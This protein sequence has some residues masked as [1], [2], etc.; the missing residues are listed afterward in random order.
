MLFSLAIITAQANET[1]AGNNQLKITASSNTGANTTQTYDTASTKF[2]ITRLSIEA[3]R[4]LASG[5]G[6]ITY[7]NEYLQVKD[8][9]I[10]S[11]IKNPTVYSRIENKITFNFQTINDLYEFKES[12][13][14]M[15]IKFEIL[16][17]GETSIN[18]NYTEFT[19]L[20]ND[21]PVDVVADNQIVDGEQFKDNIEL[22]SR[23]V[24]FRVN[25]KTKHNGVFLSTQTQEYD[26]EYNKYITV[27]IGFNTSHPI[28]EVDGTLSYD[29]TKLK[30]ISG[31]CPFSDVYEFPT[32]YTSDF[33]INAL[34]E[35]SQNPNNIPFP[36]SNR[37]L[38]T[39]TFEL[40]QKGE[41]NLDIIYNDIFMF[42]GDD[43]SF[44]RL[45]DTNGKIED[46]E[47]TAGFSNDVTPSEERTAD[48]PTTPTDFTVP[49]QPIPSDATTIKLTAPK[50]SM[51]VGSTMTVK[52]TITNQFGSVKYEVSNTKI[53]TIDANGKIKAK[54][55]GNLTVKARNNGKVASV[56]IKVIQRN[57]PVK[58]KV[59]KKVFTA[60]ANKKTTLKK[61]KLFKITKAKGKVVFYRA[62]K[63]KKFSVKK[64]GNIVVTKGLKK[65]K[66]Y[67]VK[68]KVIAKGNNVYKKKAVIKK[69]K[70]KIK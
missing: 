57:N 46:N 21:I 59:K 38:A 2:V 25:S 5:Q 33:R 28:D 30:F 36:Q 35:Y 51:Y 62:N 16:K 54:H 10:N 68:V 67:T 19:S 17:A 61:K 44:V 13:T 27:N 12:E 53:A 39:L 18:V 31:Q 26:L 43:D 64:S 55:K 70:I 40:L 63:D 11:K 42:V 6:Y 47:Y 8:I 3:A 4:L 9:V 50:K 23:N 29:K 7:D 34:Y 60:K 24:L 22:L 32:T 14:F 65:G 41:I 56:K 69:V 37:P 58:I 66:T 15:T 49:T 1:G 52:T 45:I 20:D 48:T